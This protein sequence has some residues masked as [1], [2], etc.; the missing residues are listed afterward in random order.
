MI[1]VGEK[2]TFSGTPQ[3]GFGMY[4]LYGIVMFIG[5]VVIIWGTG[6]RLFE[7]LCFAAVIIFMIAFGALLLGLAADSL[8]RRALE[9]DDLGVRLKKGEKVQWE[10]LWGE[11][12]AIGTTSWGGRT[13]RTGFYV[14]T[15]QRSFHVNTRDDL[16]PRDK[17]VEIFRLLAKRCNGMNI[18]FNDLLGWATDMGLKFP[19]AGP[20]VISTAK[21]QKGNWYASSDPNRA[22]KPVMEICLGIVGIGIAFLVLWY[23]WFRGYP[24]FLTIGASLIIAGIFMIIA[25]Y[26]DYR[27]RPLSIKFDDTG[28]ELRF[29][30]GRTRSVTWSD[31]NIIGYDSENQVLRIRANKGA[32][33]W[34][35]FFAPDVGET[36]AGIYAASRD[37]SRPPPPL[38]K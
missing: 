12:R 32:N 27:T 3:A 21:A 34:M 16:G 19:T 35:G 26:A 9:M 37:K 20:A 23:I 29:P 38:D 30:S 13:P 10:V 11:L 5:G 14:K 22:V 1:I 7:N 8:R 2:Q 4:F 36:L 28:L 33:M 18:H 31:I 24:M 25:M 17:L 15:E 6:P